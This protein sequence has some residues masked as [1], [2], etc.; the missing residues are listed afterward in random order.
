MGFRG[1]SSKS[2]NNL[3][4]TLDTPKAS[5]FVRAS[6]PV[7]RHGGTAGF[8]AP[9]GDLRRQRRFR[10]QQVGG[11]KTNLTRMPQ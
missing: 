11:H 10:H 4:K 7:S 5:I 1:S 6:I 3:V 8:I 2:E 9:T